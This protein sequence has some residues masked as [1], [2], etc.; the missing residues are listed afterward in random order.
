MLDPSTEPDPGIARF[1]SWA[2]WPALA[3]SGAIAAAVAM[4][5]AVPSF[6]T[7]APEGWSTMSPATAGG[8]LL[9]TVGLV[10]ARPSATTGSLRVALLLAFLVMA[11]GLAALVAPELNLDVAYLPS[12]QT[13][14]SFVLLGGCIA[15]MQARVPTFVPD[16]VAGAFLTFLMFMTGGHLFRA[17]AV[18]E[19]SDGRLISL[20]TLLCF[21]FLGFVITCRLAL[22]RGLF[23][24]FSDIGTGSRI[25]RGMLPVVIFLPFALFIAVAYLYEVSGFPPDI[26][27][28]LFAPLVVVGVLGLIFWMGTRI[29][30]LERGLRLQSD[31]DHMTKVLN[32]RGFSTVSEYVVRAAI[33]DKLPLV[34]LF[35]DLDGLKRVNDS[36][37]HDAGSALIRRF[38]DLLVTTFRRSD[39][40][41]RVGGDEF[42][43]L[44]V[45][46]PEGA[47]T[48]INR[49]REATDEANQTRSAP[50][51]IAYSV[52]HTLVDLESDN[53]VETALA[54]A[55]A[56]M[57]EAKRQKKAALGPASTQRDGRTPAAKPAN[58]QM[59]EWE[60]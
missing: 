23:A 35:F 37:G 14:V 32:R 58:K 15:L 44:A 57:Y 2:V 59:L 9:A 49:L 11:I 12:A 42:A 34:V 31:T 55:D 18:L 8:V 46:S 6:S 40:V 52:G 39:V 29:N 38:A 24:I 36:Y 26:V 45:A 27:R 43:V 7:I 5:W 56:F 20:Q 28:A 21:W 33:R 47:P 60:I 3:L 1:L 48:L 41:A 19:S 17:V 25:F 4:F 50:Y 51:P 53:P 13:S 22:R 30:Q 10:A 16:I 54:R